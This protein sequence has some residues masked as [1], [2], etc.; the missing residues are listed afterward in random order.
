MHVSKDSMWRGIWKILQNFLGTKQGLNWALEWKKRE[1]RG[2][3]KKGR[4]IGWVLIQRGRMDWARCLVASEKLGYC[5]SPMPA[6]DGP[7]PSGQPHAVRSLL[8][9]MCCLNLYVVRN[10]F[11]KR[12]IWPPTLAKVWFASSNEKLEFFLI[13][14]HLLKLPDFAHFGGLDGWFCPMKRHVNRDRLQN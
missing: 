6:L 14:I 8:K 12:Y 10:D 11:F 9:Y 3:K 1:N 4:R 5:K 2:K 13:L 7:P